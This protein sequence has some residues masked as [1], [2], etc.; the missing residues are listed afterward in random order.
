MNEK[1]FTIQDRI[2]AV[3]PLCLVWTNATKV[4]FMC[5]DALNKGLYCDVTF[6]VQNFY[7]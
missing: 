2:E 3:Y 5:L 6:L 7:E 4:R 1:A